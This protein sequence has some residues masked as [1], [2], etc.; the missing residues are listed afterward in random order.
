MEDTDS[1]SGIP[2]DNKWIG[3]ADCSTSPAMDKIIINPKCCPW[4]WFTR[5]IIVETMH[6]S[7][8]SD[9]YQK[10]HNYAGVI[11]YQHN[12]KSEWRTANNHSL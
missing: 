3:A 7:C 2:V 12:G 11:I 10:D 6:I 1:L 8:K 4:P 5:A 9:K